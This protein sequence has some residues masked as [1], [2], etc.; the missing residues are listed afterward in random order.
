MRNSR[1]S[2]ASVL[3]AAGLFVTLALAQKPGSKPE[4]K[5]TS[6]N[7]KGTWK[8]DTEKSDY[9]QMPKPKSM[10]LVVTEDN[11]TAV[12]WHITGTDATGKPVHESFSGAAHGKPYPITGDPRASTVAYTRNG[13]QVNGTVTMKDGSTHQE[14]ITMSDDKKTMTLKSEAT[15]PNGP[16]NFTEVWDR[17]SGGAHKSSGRKSSQ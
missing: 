7:A 3:L 13:D 2:A 11:D 16:V 9:G 10:R 1:F 6:G 12:K 5:S 15:G 17:V 14:T 4:V 8:L